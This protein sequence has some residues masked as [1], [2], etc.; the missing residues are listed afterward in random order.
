MSQPINQEEFLASYRAGRDGLLYCEFSGD[1]MTPVA[2]AIKLQSQSRHLFLLESVEQGKTRARF[3]FI[4]WQ[5]LLLWEARHGKAFHRVAKDDSNDSADNAPWQPSPIAPDQPLVDL[6]KLLEK[7]LIDFPSALPAAA[8]GFFGFLSYD[9]IQMVEKIPPHRHD[10]HGLPDG[11]YFLPKQLLIFDNS[12]DKIFLVVRCQYNAAQ[13]AADALHTTTAT[14]KATLHHLR[15]PSPATPP[16]PA[17]P[18]PQQP[19]HLTAEKDFI[20][21]AKKT[22]DYIK[23]GDIFQAVI[24]QVFQYD[25]FHGAPLSFY[26]SLRATNPAPYMFFFQWEDFAFA[27]ASPETLV[28]VQGKKVSVYPIAGT[29]PRG[30]TDAEDKKLEQ[31]LLADPKERAEHLMLLDLGRNDVGR[32]AD[33]GS[34]KVLQEFQI[35]RYSFVMHIVSEVMGDLA[36]NKTS[37]DAL[38]A[39]MP[40]GTVSGA[41]KIR[42]MEIIAE[43]EKTRRGLYAGAVGYFSCK[44]NDNAATHANQADMDHCIALRCA[45]LTG[46]KVTIQTGAGIV[47]DSIPAQ[48]QEECLNKARALFRAFDRAHEFSGN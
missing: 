44:R 9:A 46:D 31:E 4:G 39:G 30:K 26:R 47:Y 17:T 3:S 33:I 25:N 45:L 23:A 5:P 1:T 16:P 34:V 18:T 40:A 27:G 43:M 28:K 29:R 32:V 12:T 6:E 7:Y 2:A 15:Q 24:S 22:I 21:A 41:P 20:A 8:S 35:E 42:A 37:L 13:S 38:L 19:T 14:I 36:K 48:E 11:R 10:P